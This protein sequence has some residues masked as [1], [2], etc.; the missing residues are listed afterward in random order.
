L[1][2]QAADRKAAQQKREA[3]FIR[4]AANAPPSD[5]SLVTNVATGAG[6]LI[7]ATAPAKAAKVLSGAVVVISERLRD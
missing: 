4:M 5:N 1:V 3:N 2:K 6:V 7:G